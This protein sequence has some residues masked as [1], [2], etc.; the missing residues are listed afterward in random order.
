MASQRSSNRFALVSQNCPISRVRSPETAKCSPKKGKD[1]GKPQLD[2][3]RIKYQVRLPVS[4][5]TTLA[6]RLTPILLLKEMTPVKQL[7]EDR[8]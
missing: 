6:D 1:K 7:K 2:E 8:N 5:S 4:T 3:V